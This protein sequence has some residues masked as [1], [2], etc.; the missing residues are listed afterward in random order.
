MQ[1]AMQNARSVTSSDKGPSDPESSAEAAELS[2]HGKSSRGIF[3]VVPRVITSAVFLFVY[4]EKL[5]E[6]YAPRG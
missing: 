1:E 2:V 6:R 4:E 3:G 5:K